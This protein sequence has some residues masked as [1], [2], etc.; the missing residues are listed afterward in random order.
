MPFDSEQC[1]NDAA[2]YP[3]TAALFADPKN[4]IIL[5]EQHRNAAEPPSVTQPQMHLLAT[6]QRVSRRDADV[7]PAKGLGEGALAGL[8]G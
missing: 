7:A 8:T 3:F 5:H 4:L 1:L 2:E 6:S